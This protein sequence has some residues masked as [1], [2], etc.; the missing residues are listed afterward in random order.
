MSSL[1]TPMDSPEPVFTIYGGPVDHMD[2]G[3]ALTVTTVEAALVFDPVRRA[4]TLEVLEQTYVTVRSVKI[5]QGNSLED[6]HAA[7]VEVERAFASQR[8]HFSGVRASPRGTLQTPDVY[9]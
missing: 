6:D 8:S 2:T 3:E 9:R 5:S 7:R 1:V 4:R